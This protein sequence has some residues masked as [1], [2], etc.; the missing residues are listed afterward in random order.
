MEEGAGDLPHAGEAALRPEHAYGV[1]LPDVLTR[2]VVDLGGA[3]GGSDL[4]VVV[5]SDPLDHVA[6]GS[7]DE[8]EE[9]VQLVGRAQGYAL[10]VEPVQH[11]EAETTID[12]R[13][14]D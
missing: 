3:A 11:L 8:G 5:T 12:P 4:A 14:N 13:I 7:P 9:A 1:V 10:V 6:L 2:D